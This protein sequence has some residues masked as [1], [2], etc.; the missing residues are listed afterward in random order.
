MG[1][2]ASCS[3]RGRLRNVATPS[4]GL[5]SR[6]CPLVASR[7]SSTLRSSHGGPQVVARWSAPAGLDTFINGSY[8]TFVNCSDPLGNGSGSTS[9]SNCSDKAANLAASFASR[10]APWR[11][12]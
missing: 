5:V 2:L 1:V 4:S 6:P 12:V 10:S 7:R 9:F 11:T 3:A 8:S